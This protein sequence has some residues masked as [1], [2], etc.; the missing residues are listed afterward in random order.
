MTGFTGTMRLFGAVLAMLAA[1]CAPSPAKAQQMTDVTVYVVKNL[2]SSP[3]FV[4]LENGYWAEQGLN[5]QIKLT[6][7]GRNVVQ[8]LQAGET[9]F[10][11]VAIS[12]TLSVARAG[13]DKLIGVMP[14]YN[15][16]D[17]MG[18]AS[19]Y[20]IIGRRD[21]GIDPANRA[22]ILGKKLGYTAGTNEY[23][24][25]QWFRKYN[26]DIAKVQIVGMLVE[27]M[28]VALKQ[29]LVDAT[30]TWEPYGSQLIRELGA[31]VA[32][33]SRGEEGLLSD[34]VGIVVR[35]DYLKANAATVEKFAVGIAMAAKFIRENP[36][37]TAEIDARYLDGL[38]LTDATEGLR[39][40]VWDPRVSVCVIEGSIRSGNG[41][42]RLGQ[43]KMDR[44][45]V[46]SDYYD[47]SIYEKVLAKHA[48]LFAGLPP[49][50][51]TIEDC[52]GKLD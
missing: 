32:I 36:K 26:I 48:D 18:K 7:G 27:D 31:N 52:K 28:P 24:M 20:S 50:P 47:L 45:F 43:I 44:P 2:L 4:A 42:V 8:A 21:K 1:L 9:Q 23:Y 10:G 37:E 39:A 51:A 12:G 16:P 19:A 29:G 46:A 5:V 40:L 6:S 38:N 35:E 14:Y 41:M 30:V 13:G 11:H 49:L 33:V 25:K 15:A 34:N 22:S 3:H 17:Y